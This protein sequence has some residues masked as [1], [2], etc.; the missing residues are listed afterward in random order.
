MR[1][2]DIALTDSSSLLNTWYHLTTVL[3]GTTGRI[4][5]NGNMTA[6]STSISPPAN[7]V[8][9]NC[10]IGDDGSTVAIDELKFFN[11][12]LT[13]AEIRSDYSLNGNLV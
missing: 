11:R 10:V 3:S 8:K 1:S 13:E 2:H 9:T 5:V 12:T 4:Y 6:Q 7:T